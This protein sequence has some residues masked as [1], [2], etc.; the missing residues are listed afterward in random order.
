MSPLKKRGTVEDI[1]TLAMECAWE[2]VLRGDGVCVGM[3]SR[4]DYELLDEM[5]DRRAH[6]AESELFEEAFDGAF[7]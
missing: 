3:P 4:E 7:K 2:W 6:A 1:K 5:L